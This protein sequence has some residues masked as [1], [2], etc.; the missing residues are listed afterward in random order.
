MME[1]IWFWVQF[2]DFC[3]TVLNN[4]NFDWKIWST[5]VNFYITMIIVRK[6]SKIIK[7]F[8]F[9]VSVRTNVACRRENHWKGFF[10]AKKKVLTKS[11]R[12]NLSLME[13]S[14]FS[15]PCNRHF[16]KVVYFT[17]YWL[18]SEIVIGIPDL[19]KTFSFQF[20]TCRISRS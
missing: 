14:Y 13:G 5:I 16:K 8:I 17:G 9:K 4:L 15:L 11:N 3:V 18:L 7:Y 6:K 20:Q 1:F 10:K 12:R 19:L 2:F